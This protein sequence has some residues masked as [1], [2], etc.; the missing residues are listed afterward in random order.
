MFKF[1]V[2]IEEFD[3]VKFNSIDYS[4]SGP[5]LFP[6]KCIRYFCESHMQCEM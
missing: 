3:A 4:F 6:K 5:S 1:T 2:Q